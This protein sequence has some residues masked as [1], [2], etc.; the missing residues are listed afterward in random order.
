MSNYL[1]FRIS[2]SVAFIT[3]SRPEA[4]NSLTRELCLALQSALKHCSENSD[5]RAILITGTGKAFSAGQDLK[6]ATEADPATVRLMVRELYNPIILAMRNMPKPIVCAVNGI[7]AGAGANIALAGD[8]VIA[9]ESASFMQA[10]SPIGLI[11]D[12]GGTFSLPRLVGQ[13]KALALSMLAEKVTAHDAERMGMV[14]RVVGGEELSGESTAIAEKLAAMP[15]KALALTKKLINASFA[16]SLEQQLAMEEAL[17][18]ECAASSDF[19]EGVQAF[20]EKRKPTFKG[21]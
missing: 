11:P 3:I 9:A 20:L 13:Q 8:V 17:Q 14:Y 4:Y 6:E 2:N 1:D 7:A 12:S 19:S 16:H 15:T 5:V 21:Y 10:F 18:G